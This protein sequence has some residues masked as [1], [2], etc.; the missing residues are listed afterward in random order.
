MYELSASFGSLAE[1][2]LHIEKEALQECF[3][4]YWTQRLAKDDGARR[5]LK[6]YLAEERQVRESSKEQGE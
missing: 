4:N 1:A 5:A 6:A 2:D 3:G